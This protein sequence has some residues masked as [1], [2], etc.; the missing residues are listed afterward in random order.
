MSNEYTFARFWRCALQVNPVDYN[1][2]YR[3]ADHGFSENDYNQALLQKLN[4]LSTGQQCTAILHMLL[5]E[6]VDPLPLSPNASSLNCVRR[7][8]AVNFYLRRTTPTFQYSATPNGSVSSRLQRT[9]GTWA[10]RCRARSMYQL[11]VIRLPGSWKVVGMPLFS[12]KKNT[13]SSLTLPPHRATAL[14][15]KQNINF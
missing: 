15:G 8:P 7:R 4:K 6:N 11:F 9:K 14:G 5:L 10:S 12:A 3:G 13:S 1:G 2:T